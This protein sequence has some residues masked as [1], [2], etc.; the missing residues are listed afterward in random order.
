MTLAEAIDTLAAE[1]LINQP[2][3]GL[4]YS[5]STDVQGASSRA[6]GQTLPVFLRERIFSRC[7]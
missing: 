7:A 3:R 4:V 2:G 1:P 5:L 6:S